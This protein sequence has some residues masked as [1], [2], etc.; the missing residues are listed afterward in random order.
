MKRFI[1]PLLLCCLPLAQ[2][3][4]PDGPPARVAGEIAALQQ[5]LDGWERAYREGA[6]TI[7]DDLYDQARATLDSWQGCLAG[8]PA[9]SPT[10]R[11]EAGP[12]A[13]PV[14]Q[15]GLAKLADERAVARWMAGREDLWIQPKVDGVAVT[16]VYR[17]GVLQQAISRGDGRS[18]QD[19][20]A[21][22][23]QI[24]AIPQRLPETLDAVFQGELYWRSEGHRQARDGAAGGRARVAGLLNRRVLKADEGVGIGL[25]VWDW[26]DGPA[27]MEARLQRLAAL[28]LVDSQALTRPLASAAEAAQW[29]ERWFRDALP[30]ATDGVVLRQGR[31]PP[32]ERW[33]AAEPDWAVAWKHPPRQALAAVRRVD[34]RVGRSGRITPLLELEP[35]E[36]DGVTVRRLSLGS[37]SRWRQLDLG[38][39]D[40]V[41]IALA[42]Q[43]IP[44]LESVLWRSAR[45]RPL[46]APNPA[47]HHPLSCWRPEPGCAAQFHARLLWLGGKDGLGFSG[48]GAGTWQQ[49]LD[50]GVLG[51]LLDWMSLQE[52]DLH[53]LPGFGPARIANLRDNA[54][55]ARQRPFRRWLRAL[56]APPAAVPG[57]RDWQTLAQRGPGDWQREAGVGAAQARRLVD[58]FAHPQVQALAARLAQEGVDGFAPAAQDP[59]Q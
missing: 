45:D 9:T 37:L 30:F 36:L 40:R 3:T 4:C 49:L 57:A 44:R 13:H 26:P 29:R 10:A 35:V 5:R 18:G 47:D 27:H 22:A 21:H 23:G 42:G 16:L 51:S 50:A 6:P 25:F 14:A 59:A 53:A 32:G 46:P 56:G 19:W 48:V 24:A 41:S 34:F 1:G 43:S 55:R 12:Q 31:R 17:A 8:L 52:A 38:P 15:T 39:G 58:F 20:R 11:L 54:Q 7:A 28:G 2:A 33:I